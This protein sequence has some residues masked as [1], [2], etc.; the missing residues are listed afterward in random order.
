MSSRLSAAIESRS[1]P[2]NPP[3]MAAILGVLTLGARSGAC[4][5]WFRMPRPKYSLGSFWF[6][7]MLPS[8]GVS[9]TR[10]TASLRR[11]VTMI[12]SAANYFHVSLAVEPDR[13]GLLG[14]LPMLGVGVN[15]QAL[16]H[17]APQGV[18]LQHTPHSFPQRLLRLA[19]DHLGE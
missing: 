8:P 4:S 1:R 18:V 15:L 6:T 12:A 10:A 16:E 13:D 9:R 5:A 19:L 14:L 11:P 17:L 7:V 3:Y 2:R